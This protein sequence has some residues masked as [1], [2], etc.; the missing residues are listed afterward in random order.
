VQ[1]I[2]FRDNSLDSIAMLISASCKF[3]SSP[4]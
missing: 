2:V 1:C 3:D 4:H